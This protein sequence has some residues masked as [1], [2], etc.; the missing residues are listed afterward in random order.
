M[1]L[2]VLMFRMYNIAEIRPTLHL[3]LETKLQLDVFL[4]WRDA[5][6]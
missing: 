1:W 5:S 3:L 2:K 4:G 6:T